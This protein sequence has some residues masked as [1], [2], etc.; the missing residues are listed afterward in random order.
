VKLLAILG[1]LAPESLSGVMLM[2][3]FEGCIEFFVKFRNRLQFG[4]PFEYKSCG[5][6]LGNS[7][8]CSGLILIKILEFGDSELFATVFSELDLRIKFNFGFPP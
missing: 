1:Q 3:E 8:I 4:L 6:V 7:G 2:L 5:F